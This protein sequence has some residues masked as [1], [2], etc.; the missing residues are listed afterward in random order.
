MFYLEC[1][2]LV[3]LRAVARYTNSISRIKKPI[4]S[5][6]LKIFVHCDLGLGPPKGRPNLYWSFPPYQG[7]IKAFSAWPYRLLTS[8]MGYGSHISLVAHPEFIN[9]HPY[10]GHQNTTIAPAHLSLHIIILSRLVL[11]YVPQKRITFIHSSFGTMAS[12]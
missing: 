1:Y 9:C 2:N 8:E 3:T 5:H 12:Q 10:N 7:P 4:L 6:F 11:S